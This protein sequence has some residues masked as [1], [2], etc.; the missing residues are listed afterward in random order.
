VHART[1]TS[2]CKSGIQPRAE[3]RN[4][5]DIDFCLQLFN[6]ALHV[7]VSRTLFV[8]SVLAREGMTLHQQDPY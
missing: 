4:K 2:A 5:A 8:F 6:N 1:L 3:D 7:G